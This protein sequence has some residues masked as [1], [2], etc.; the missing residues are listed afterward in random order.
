MFVRIAPP[1]TPSDVNVPEN[2]GPA[3]LCTDIVSGTLAAGVTATVTLTTSDGSAQRKKTKHSSAIVCI[4]DHSLNLMCFSHQ[5]LVI[6][7]W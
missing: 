2:G 1:V 6:T 4:E 5:N 3:Q 7:Q